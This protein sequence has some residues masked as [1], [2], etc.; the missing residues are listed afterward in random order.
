[1][2]FNILITNSTCV[3][4]NNRNEQLLITVACYC[5]VVKPKSFVSGSIIYTLKLILLS[6]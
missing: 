5:I 4:F 2:I 3:V 6:W 1:M